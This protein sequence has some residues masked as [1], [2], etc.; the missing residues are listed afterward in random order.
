MLS[1]AIV[2]YKPRASL[3]ALK[4]ARIFSVEAEKERRNNNAKV[5]KNLTRDSP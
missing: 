3:M 1:K 5:T 2:D 4:I